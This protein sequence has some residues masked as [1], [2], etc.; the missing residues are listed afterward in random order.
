M[1]CVT[2]GA[3]YCFKEFMGAL[4]TLDTKLYPTLDGDTFGP[5]EVEKVEKILEEDICTTC[6]E[7]L[8]D[9]MYLT[10]SDATDDEKY[11]R[12]YMELMCSM[13]PDDEGEMQWCLPVTKDMEDEDSPEMD[14]DSA[15]YDEDEIDVYV[16]EQS[17]LWCDDLCVK[18]IKIK[19]KEMTRIDLN[20]EKSY[21]CRVNGIPSKCSQASIDA[22]EKQ[23]EQ[24]EVMESSYCGKVR[25]LMSARACKHLV[26]LLLKDGAMPPVAACSSRC[27]QRDRSGIFLLHGN[28][29]I[30]VVLGEM[31]RM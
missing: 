15:D 29:G 6:N 7:K 12:A 28:A 1:A 9:Y 23:M 30:A 22:K 14:E 21:E 19:E 18:T 4:R 11:E 10:W 3:D 20:A 24:E 16:E 13:A 17:D 2:D 25:M 27:R 26:T 31:G 8:M 5:T